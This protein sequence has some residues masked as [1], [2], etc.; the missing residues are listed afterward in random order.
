MTNFGGEFKS[1]DLT[2]FF[3]DLGIAIHTSMPY[4]H[5]QNGCA[6]HFN[7]TIMENAQAIHLDA[8]I[9]QS[10]WEFAVLH[11]VHLYNR[12][13]VCYIDW[14][15]SYEKLEHQAPDVSLDVELTSSSLEKSILI[16]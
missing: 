11:A 6:E 9:P 1:L 3:K 2:D 12:T 4:M 8:C 5:Q 13:P 16:N 10:W 14:K 15:M 7:R